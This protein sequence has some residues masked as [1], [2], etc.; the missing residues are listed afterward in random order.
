VISHGRDYW[1]YSAAD[2]SARIATTRRTGEAS[3]LL[4]AVGQVLPIAVAVAVS[5]VPITIVILI[6][7]S[8]NRNRA[9]IPFLIGWVVGIAA[10]TLGFTFLS[11]VLPVAA[12]HRPELGIGTTLMLVGIALIVFAIVSWRRARGKPVT[13]SLP[14]WLRAVGSIGPL[15]ALGLALI[16]NVRPK[17]LLLS[18]A[19]GV[20]LDSNQLDVAST[21]VVIVIYT[22]V[23]G[24]TIIVPIVF[25]LLS[26][27]RM[28][29]RLV[30][31]RNWLA[32]NNRTVSILIMLVM[33]VVV[34]SSGLTRL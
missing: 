17:A 22:L 33:G 14:R 10:V 32:R 5:S 34:F 11:R 27:K 6:L 21:I 7:L 3:L 29:P 19:A 25:T 24:S 4:Q 31:V 16:L 8:P 18:I 1:D 26:P 15:P 2:L 13:E 9:A 23:A 30:S 12:S 28:E 20:S